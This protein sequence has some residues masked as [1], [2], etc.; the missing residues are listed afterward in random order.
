MNNMAVKP[1]IQNSTLTDE[2]GVTALSVATSGGVTLGVSTTS[3]AHLFQGT[4]ASASVGILDIRNYDTGDDNPCLRIGTGA[5]GTTTANKIVN[6]LRGSNVQGAIVCNGA[7]VAAFGSYSDIRL[8]RNIKP[9]GSELERIC[10]LNPVSFEW[11][12]GTGM[13]IGFI[14]QEIEEH[15]PDSVSYVGPNTDTMK[16]IAG[17]DKTTARLVKAIQELSAKVDSLQSELNTLKG[18]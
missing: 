16:T 12:D 1:I 15:Y 3:S 14:A 2:N 13:Q 5:T 18:Q 11:A 17:W 7:G 8:K 9:L 10:S 4:S 6:F